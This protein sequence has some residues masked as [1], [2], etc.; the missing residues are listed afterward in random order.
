MQRLLLA[1]TGAA[2]A[3]DVI[4]VSGGSF[5]P[6]YYLFD[7]SPDVPT[8]EEGKAYRF[9]DGGVD[10]SHPFHLS[11]SLDASAPGASDFELPVEFTFSG[12]P[13]GYY[14]AAHSSMS[15]SFMI[16]GS[17][18]DDTN[19]EGVRRRARGARAA[20]CAGAGGPGAP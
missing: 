4:T 19:N 3:V 16:E 12:Q 17:P 11:G 20:A 2:S 13:V 6:P 10:P 9:E 5:T 18:S 8:L 15:G 7:G 14:C 1:L